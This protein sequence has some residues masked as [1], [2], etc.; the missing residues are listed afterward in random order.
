LRRA[1]SITAKEVMPFLIATIA[2]VVAGN[3]TIWG[4]LQY[5]PEVGSFLRVWIITTL[6]LVAAFA[7]PGAVIGA[8]AS[9]Q[10]QRK[11]SL[12]FFDMNLSLAFKLFQFSFEQKC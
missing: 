6:N 4:S 2:L 12:P 9:L 8:R 7:A 11:N 1:L 5:I 3:A 10:W